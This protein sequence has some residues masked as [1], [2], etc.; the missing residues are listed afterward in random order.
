MGSVHFY[1]WPHLAGDTEPVPEHYRKIHT[2]CRDYCCRKKKFNR[3]I[4][5]S[6]QN[7]VAAAFRHKALATSPPTDKFTPDASGGQA[8]SSSSLSSSSSSSSSS[9]VQVAQQPIMAARQSPARRRCE[10]STVNEICLE[11]YR[12]EFQEKSREGFLQVSVKFSG[13]DLGGIPETLEGVGIAYGILG[14]VNR[15]KS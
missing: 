6:L 14:R 10:G 9:S 5:P 7:A 2:T 11:E 13:G 15:L 4:D 3:S 1:I 8:T 12:Q